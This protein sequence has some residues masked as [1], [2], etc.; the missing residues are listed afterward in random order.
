MPAERSE[1]AEG[2]I[3][4]ESVH[5]LLMVPMKHSVAYTVEFLK[6]KSACGYNVII[7]D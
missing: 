4:Q 7:S 2:D 6:G 5:L 3:M 1:I